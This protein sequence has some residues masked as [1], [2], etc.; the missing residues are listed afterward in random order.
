MPTEK[1]AYELDWWVLRPGGGQMQCEQRELV[2]LG[3]D[4]PLNPGWL[5]EILIS[6]LIKIPILG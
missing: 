3:F 4:I 1:E 6:W 2:T 5:I